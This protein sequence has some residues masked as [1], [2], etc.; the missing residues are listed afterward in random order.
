[1]Q[2]H[3]EAASRELATNV[4]H[5][6]LSADLQRGVCHRRSHVDR[7]SQ[8]IPPIASLS[9]EIPGRDKEGGWTVAPEEFWC[10]RVEVVRVAIVEC[11]DDSRRSRFSRY[12]VQR[13]DVGNSGG[14]IE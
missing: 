2:R 7:C 13:N 9:V 6:T 14:T 1:M 4:D 10:R 5:Q 11:H 12:V 3:V 8:S